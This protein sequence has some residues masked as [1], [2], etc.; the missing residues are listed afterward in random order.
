MQM[1]GSSVALMELYRLAEID[2]VA[3]MDRLIELDS[4]FLGNLHYMAFRPGVVINSGIALGDRL[5]IRQG[6]DSLEKALASN[7]HILDNW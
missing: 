7:D 3:V 5:K 2:P 4:E 6:V 1:S